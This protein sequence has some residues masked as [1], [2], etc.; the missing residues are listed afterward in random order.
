MYTPELT[1]RVG[2]TR[3]AAGFL[4]TA[5]ATSLPEL[6]TTIAAVRRGALTL[7][8]GNIVG[9]NAFDTLFC[10]ISDVAYTDG[11]IYAA[12]TSQELVVTALGLTLTCLLLMGMIGRER[13][14][15][16]KIGAESMLILVTYVLG[17]LYIGWPR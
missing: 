6:V 3:S 16:A 1:D 15:V 5:T 11:S 9:G 4:I 12:A 14:G 7:A 13:R 2:L 10:S 8:V 17:A